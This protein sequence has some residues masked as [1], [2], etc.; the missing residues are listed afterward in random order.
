MGAMLED[1]AREVAVGL[2]NE[3]SRIILHYFEKGAPAQRKS[4]GTPVTEADLEINHLVMDR[5]GQ[6]FPDHGFIGEELDGR[7]SAGEYVWLC[8]PVDGTLPFTLGFPVSTFV[9]SLV[10]QGKPILGVMAYPARNWLLVGQAGKGTV[11]NGRSVHV[12]DWPILH[13]SVID[14][15]PGAPGLFDAADAAGAFVVCYYS[16][17]TSA[18]MVARGTMT[19]SIWPGTAPWDVA[20]SKVIVEEAGGRVTA[21]D[22][23]DQRYDRPLRGAIVSNGKVHDQLVSLVRDCGVDGVARSA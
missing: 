1:R 19:A 22:G 18:I 9:L 8:D 20:A 12:S 10:R 13:Q 14:T 4:D 17:C 23:G 5:I 7:D 2:A 21:L 6:E 11:L 15:S 16:I 3:A